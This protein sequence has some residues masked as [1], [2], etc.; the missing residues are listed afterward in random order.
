MDIP[1]IK[2]TSKLP[3]PEW[4]VMEWKLIEKMESA[5]DIYIDR[6][7]LPDGTL[8][9]KQFWPGMD[10]ADDG[11]ESFQ[12]FPLLYA[13]GGDESILKRSHFYWDSVTWQFTEYGQVYNEY[14]KYYDWMHHGEGNLFFYYMALADPMS[15]KFATRA[16]RFAD[17]YTGDLNYDSEKRII[18]AP[19]NGSYGPRHKHSGED[20]ETHRAV[21]DNYL[22]PFE[23]MPDIPFG[24]TCPWSD[25][26]KYKTILEFINKRMAKGDVPLNLNATSLATHAYMYTG[27]EKY[28]TW[29]LDYLSAWEERTKRNGGLIPD[30]VG[31]NDV[32]GENMDGKWWGGY[33]GWRWPHG[34]ST[35]IEPLINAGNNALML[36]GDDKWLDL[37]R[38]QMDYLYE[39]RKVDEN[40]NVTIPVKHFDTGWGQYGRENTKWPVYCWSV[41]QSEADKKRI[42]RL[43]DKENWG[44]VPKNLEKGNRMSIHPWFYY[45]EGMN[46]DFP[47]QTLEANYNAVLKRLD[48]I[49]NDNYDRE[50]VD[51]HHFQ[52]KNPVVCEA[53]VQLM[54]GGSTN[55]YHGGLMYT[56][57][58][59]FH[60]G[61]P[62]LPKGVGALVDKVTESEI[63]VT[64]HNL[65]SD[66][67]EFILQ[68]G[69]FG[70]HKILSANGIEVNGKYLNVELDGNCQLELKLKVKR[71]A[72]QPSYRT[73]YMTDADI[74]NPIIHRNLEN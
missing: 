63:S 65:N 36:T 11:Y 22:P 25:D 12:N 68:G 26:E 37:A 57:L 24:K 42:D 61:R 64:L 38:S 74:P 4:A 14:F 2:S 23:D 27:D 53:L 16:T 69:F 49:A 52:D 60:D 71:F 56:A 29:V 31:L 1:R 70:E 15:L 62:G 5:I 35:V 20:W 43:Q 7:T 32:I 46:P 17:F 50:E 45:L 73:P 72:E 6:Y 66:T 13:L 51:V 33:Y 48:D 47:M 28:K 3:A 30:N 40:G 59:Y 54:T 21:L 44:V 8:K 34:A 41:T 67:K 10:G 9:W 55:I 58:R 18:K 39:M 19:I